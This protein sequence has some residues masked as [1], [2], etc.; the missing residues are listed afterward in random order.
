M[1]WSIATLTLCLLSSVARAQ[2][3]DF[4]TAVHF[5]SVSVG[6]VSAGP[7]IPGWVFRPAGPGPFPAVVLEHTCA[8][9]I[10]DVN[11][12]GWL[13][14]KWGY[15]A[16][17]PDSF[18]P[19]R[20][21]SICAD[22]NVVSLDA[23]VADIAGALDYLATRP[24]VVPA[25]FGLI[26]HSHGGSATVRAVQEEYDLTKRGLRG[27]VAYYPGCS[28]KRDRNVALP[29]LVLIGQQD[30]WMLPEWCRGLQQAGFKRPEL[31]EIVYYPGAY[32]AF[33]GHAEQK[34]RG[35]NRELHQLRHDPAA[36]RDAEERTKVFFSRL[37]R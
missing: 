19:R 18:T 11:D 9:Y 29:L 8:G 24:D 13:L 20:E 22:L 26:G 23:R 17:A 30:D 25:R 34:V 2:S 21:F 5:P 33:D 28:A 32:H 36:A 7:V 4:P 16:L 15:L 35:E 12:W 6:G 1:I 37:L 14:A 10:V 3:G 27:G 31:V